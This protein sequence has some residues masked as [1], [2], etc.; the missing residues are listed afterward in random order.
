VLSPKHYYCSHCG[1]D[2]DSTL[3]LRAHVEHAAAHANWRQ[4][5]DADAGWP[6]GFMTSVGSTASRSSPEDESLLSIFDC[7]GD[8]SLYYSLRA[9]FQV[10]GELT[11]Y[12]TVSD[13]PA[14]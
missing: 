10:E 2:H 9:Q 14:A 7:Y 11:K 1:T 13:A 8:R 6:D 5:H 12:S 3:E 4:D